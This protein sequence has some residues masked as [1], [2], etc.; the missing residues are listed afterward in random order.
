MAALACDRPAARAVF[1]PGWSYVCKDEQLSA[2]SLLVFVGLFSVARARRRETCLT[3]PE[4]HWERG[5]ARG[6]ESGV[7]EGTK[8]ERE[9][10]T[11]I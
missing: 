11:M 7:R 5:Q 8:K 1:L 4:K 9:R 3:F 2:F 10:D 6:R